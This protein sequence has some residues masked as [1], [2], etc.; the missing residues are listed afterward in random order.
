MLAHVQLLAQIEALRK[1][2]RILV[3]HNANAPDLEKRQPQLSSLY[4][5][6]HA[7]L[8]RAG[9]MTDMKP[10]A[11]VHSKAGSQRVLRGL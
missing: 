6:R 4:D 11:L 7:A 1:K 3:E 8:K 2:L 9:H 5:F 10:R